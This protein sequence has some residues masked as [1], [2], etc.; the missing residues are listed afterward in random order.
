MPPKKAASV[1]VPRARAGSAKAPSSKTSGLRPMPAPGLLVAPP[2]HTGA[3]EVHADA[4]A[5]CEDVPGEPVTPAP[6]KKVPVKKVPA[7][8]ATATRKPQPA[9]EDPRTENVEAGDALP[10]ET[11][12]GGEANVVS[13]PDEG[14]ETGAITTADLMDTGARREAACKRTLTHLL[15]VLDQMRMSGSESP[16]QIVG[17]SRRLLENG[18]NLEDFVAARYARACRVEC[19]GSVLRVQDEE[20]PVDEDGCVRVNA[21]VLKAV[22]V[23]YC[24]YVMMRYTRILAMNDTES[25]I[26]HALQ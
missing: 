1:G 17:A 16:E 7:K 12:E 8:R 11:E 10:G 24:E 2:P 25:I 4:V 19:D 26:A 9:P 15:A 13:Q 21:K 23:R 3:Q 20:F 5:Q 14:D 22:I 18:E 6:A